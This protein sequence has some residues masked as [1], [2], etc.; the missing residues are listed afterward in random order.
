MTFFNQ[1][2]KQLTMFG[3]TV[4]DRIQRFLSYSSISWLGLFENVG[5][6]IPQRQ[7]NEADDAY[8]LRS[9]QWLENVLNA[10][11][12]QEGQ[13]FSQSSQRIMRDELTSD[14]FLSSAAGS[15]GSSN[16]DVFFNDRFPPTSTKNINRQRTFDSVPIA[17]LLYTICFS[18]ANDFEIREIINRLVVQGTP[19][20]VFFMEKLKSC[21]QSA[22]G[23]F[24][25]RPIVIDL[26]PDTFLDLLD[27][28]NTVWDYKYLRSE[29]GLTA[30]F[31]FFARL[32]KYVGSYIEFTDN[33][34]P[35][36]IDAGFQT[37]ETAF[38]F[39]PF[40]SSAERQVQQQNTRI[41][42]RVYAQVKGIPMVSSTTDVAQ[43]AIVPPLP[44]SLFGRILPEHSYGLKPNMVQFVDSFLLR[45]SLLDYDKK[46]I[47]IGF[48]SPTG[49]INAS[50]FNYV[51]YVVGRVTGQIH[52]GN[53]FT[54]PD[55]QTEEDSKPSS[56]SGARAHKHGNTSA[57]GGRKRWKPNDKSE[58]ISK[59]AHRFF[60]VM[61]ALLENQF[62][63]SNQ[64]TR[65]VL[66]LCRPKRNTHALVASSQ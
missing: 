39:E 63:N 22:A 20:P 21:R 29:Q 51:M 41:E 3:I 11:L 48:F 38:S 54:I 56:T 28:K 33:V 45:R 6:T 35:I 58:F 13:M 32:S 59:S 57:K 62:I 9:T 50:T 4:Q 5:G 42:K 1:I 37:T 66:G 18:L 43:P 8:A 40:F 16:Q 46:P 44:D 14:P 61:K 25:I 36:I 47:I 31:Q 23:P 2:E 49:E 19:V 55:T 53:E 65:L 24:F 30:L 7:P 17:A 26:I 34:K 12:L 10:F 27:L 52:N 64:F 15:R 60:N